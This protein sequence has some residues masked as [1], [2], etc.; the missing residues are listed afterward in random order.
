MGRDRDESDFAK[1]APSTT[2]P[3]TYIEEWREDAMRQGLESKEAA[4]VAEIQDA[5]KKMPGGKSHGADIGLTVDAPSPDARQGTSIKDSEVRNLSTD[6][7][8]ALDLDLRPSLARAAGP[9]R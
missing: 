7:A 4:G 1:K 3:A 6:P 9:G 2:D 5:T 8:E